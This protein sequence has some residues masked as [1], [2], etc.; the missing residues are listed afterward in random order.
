MFSIYDGASLKNL[1]AFFFLFL[2][3]CSDKVTRLAEDAQ[4]DVCTVVSV[5]SSTSGMHPD[6]LNGRKGNA[7]R[8]LQSYIFLLCK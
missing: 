4:Y 7:G 2:T 3:C 6:L 1:S 8:H 5:C